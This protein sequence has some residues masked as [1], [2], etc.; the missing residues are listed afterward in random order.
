MRKRFS[1]NSKLR[2]VFYVED[3]C[4]INGGKGF[5]DV[6][7]AAL[8]AGPN[9]GWLAYSMCN[10]EPRW[11]S[12]FLSFSCDTA[13]HCLAKDMPEAVFIAPASLA[14]QAKHALTGRR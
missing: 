10:G 8:A 14:H 2:H 7:E 5:R 11:G 6:L 1:L 12:H 9:I 13:L 3:D 4:R